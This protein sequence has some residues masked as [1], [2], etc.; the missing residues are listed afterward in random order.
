[1][2]V[3]FGRLEKKMF[4]N[5]FSNPVNFSHQGE[6]KKKKE[7]PPD[8]KESHYI[9]YSSHIVCKWFLLAK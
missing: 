3:T 8:V 9:R 5:H 1:M 2:Y 6:K 7:K 4:L